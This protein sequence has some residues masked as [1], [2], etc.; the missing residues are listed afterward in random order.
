MGSR[1]LL[2]GLLEDMIGNQNVYYNPPSNIQ[3]EWPAIKFEPS[4]I[5][6]LRANN[7]L[8]KRTICY[9]VTVVGKLPNDSIVEKL[10]SLPMCSFDRHYTSDGLIHDVLRLYF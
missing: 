5:D 2:Q 6:T 1:L 10:L 9:S 4:K 3:M 8:Y 7:A